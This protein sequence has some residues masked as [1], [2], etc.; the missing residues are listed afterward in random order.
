MEVFDHTE[1]LF[2][3]AVIDQEIKVAIAQFELEQASHPY[4]WKHDPDMKAANI[5]ML[6]GK[7]LIEQCHYKRD[8][9]TLRDYLDNKA[10]PFE[11]T[12]VYTAPKRGRHS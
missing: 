12:P 8:L 9:K 5:T 4:F 11:E 6:T 1:W 3:R 10:K 7:M 2:R